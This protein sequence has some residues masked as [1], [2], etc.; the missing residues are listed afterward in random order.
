MA[1]HSDFVWMYTSVLAIT[2]MMMLQRWW[3]WCNLVPRALF[4][5]FG[6]STSKAR[7][8]R[9]GDEVGWWWWWWWWLW[10]F[11][12]DRGWFIMI[13][14]LVMMM[15]DDCD[16]MIV[17]TWQEL[18]YRPPGDDNEKLDCDDNDDDEDVWTA[19]GFDKKSLREVAR[20]AGKY[21]IYGNHN[22]LAF[23]LASLWYLS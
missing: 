6:L 20:A 17:M 23:I 16:D 9:S 1:D 3:W 8:K 13:K 21:F 5:G 12:D 10:R 14:R 2:K 4:P 15:R 7:E 19:S 11:G 18:I 22:M